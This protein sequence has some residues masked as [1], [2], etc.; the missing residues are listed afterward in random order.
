MLNHITDIAYFFLSFLF[1]LF[2]V[3]LLDLHWILSSLCISSF[4]SLYITSFLSSVCLHYHQKP[5]YI[6]FWYLLDHCLS[7]SFSDCGCVFPSL[8]AFLPNSLCPPLCLSHSI[9]V[10][11]FS[12]FSLDLSFCWLEHVL[13]ICVV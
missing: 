5:N 7:M 6:S 11:L 9:F 8:Y 3:F 12:S 4:L 1:L 2:S 10:S 13:I